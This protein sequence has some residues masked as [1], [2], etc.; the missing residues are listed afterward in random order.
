[1]KNDV[2]LENVRENYTSR[3]EIEGLFVVSKII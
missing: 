3:N 2:N 1:M